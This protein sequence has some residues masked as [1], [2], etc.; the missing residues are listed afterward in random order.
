MSKKSSDA[1]L[2]G[3]IATIV[4]GLVVLVVWAIPSSGEI[5][6]DSGD[7]GGVVET[8]TKRTEKRLGPIE[9][10]LRASLELTT[11]TARSADEVRKLATSAEIAR[12]L[13]PKQCG[14]ACDAIRKLLDDEDAFELDVAPVDDATLPG[15]ETWDTVAASLTPQERESLSRK[16]TSVTLRANAPFSK[17]HLAARAGFAATAILAEALDGFV[18]DETTRRIQRW[19]D[20]PVITVPLGAPA[21][22]RKDIV[23]QLFR[24]EDGTARA[25]TLG[26]MR[27]G[28]PDLTLQGANM[29]AGPRLAELLNAAASKLAAGETQT[30]ISL[31]LAD[32]ARVVGRLP[33]ELNATPEGARPIELEVV[34][35]EREEGDPDNELAELVPKDGSTREA[36]DSVVASI[37]GV[38]ATVTTETDDKE[39]GD[40]AA[41]ARGSLGKAIA[42]FEAG[43][44]EFFV[45]GPFVIPPDARLDGGP[46]TEM[47]WVAVASCDAKLCTGVLSSEP[48]YVTNLAAA[49]TTSVERAHAVDWMI[50]GRD[51][52]TTGGESLRVLRARASAR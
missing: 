31:G 13:G 32:V 23:V 22:E 3:G 37:F 50:R 36:W 9:R 7:D 46:L 20:S 45:R 21:F 39:L 24:Q 10:P 35:P 17:D 29:S 19:Q 4:L 34:A 51:G 28:C 25:L 5:G 12:R 6:H 30:P 8:T 33:A 2:Y 47:L 44:G 14:D 38:P 41:H 49:K 18:Y 52:G 26:L 11:V 16:T 40:V 1:K 27:F 43:A 15:K 42:R 48:T